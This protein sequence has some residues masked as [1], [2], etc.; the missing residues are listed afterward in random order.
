MPMLAMRSRRYSDRKSQR[1]S[2][3]LHLLRLDRLTPAAVGAI[4]RGKHRGVQSTPDIVGDG[5]HR[6]IA[7]SAG[8]ALLL[9]ILTVTHLCCPVL[10]LCLSVHARTTEATWA[11]CSSGTHLCHGSI[12]ATQLKRDSRLGYLTGRS[13]QGPLID[14][15]RQPRRCDC[16]SG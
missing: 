10:S 5:D 16:G 9:C 15:I 11:H 2:T 8:P 3:R 14:G 12:T 4:G 1:I 6:R 13:D 7:S